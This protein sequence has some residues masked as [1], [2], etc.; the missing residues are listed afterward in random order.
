MKRKLEAYAVDEMYPW[1]ELK[2]MIRVSDEEL[3]ATLR[4]L[5]SGVDTHGNCTIVD[6][7][8]IHQI[9]DY[10]ILE[11]RNSRSFCGDLV[12]SLEDTW[13]FCPDVAHRC[14]E[15]HDSTMDE[16]D[17]E[18]SDPKH[19]HVEYAR[20]ILQGRGDKMEICE[21]VY[22]LR[23]LMPVNLDLLDGE[24]LVE[25]DGDQVWVFLPSDHNTPNANTLT[26]A[27]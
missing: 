5:N 1:D 11:A 22:Q 26:S 18:Y 4:L 21:F 19:L 2:S 3:K 17:R 27:S 9:I 12:Q 16:L 10:I 23:Q 24:I 13:G 15:L 8:K 6:D 7:S 14:L 20:Q 25:K